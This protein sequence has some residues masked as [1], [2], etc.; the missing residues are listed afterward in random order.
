M[1]L[2]V[3]VGGQAVDIF[4]GGQVVDANACAA[5]VEVY[6]GP[7]APII[8]VYLGN[9]GIRGQAASVGFG[10]SLPG[11]LEA[12]EDPIPAVT[13]GS[14]ALTLD[15]CSARAH[16]G[17]PAAST[18]VFRALRNGVEVATITFAAGATEGVWTLATDGYA[19][20]DYWELLPPTIPDAN[21]RGYA[22][23]FAA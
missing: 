11:F 21:L 10:F 7:E 1:L 9:E 12:G 15:G 6:L 8:D 23:V 13:R 2:D 22:F 16:P 19:D 20:G 5:P 17:Y 18:T 4:I 14:G 3:H